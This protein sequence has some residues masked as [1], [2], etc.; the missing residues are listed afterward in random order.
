MWDCTQDFLVFTLQKL[1]SIGQKC[2]MSIHGM[3][4][5]NKSLINLM[6]GSHKLIALTEREA[7]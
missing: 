4:G 1:K 7:K 6:S 5:N 2:P 3:N